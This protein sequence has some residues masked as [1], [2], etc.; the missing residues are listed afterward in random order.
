MWWVSEPYI[1]LR[2]EDEPLGYQPAL[3]PRVAFHLSYRQRG[4]APEDP[5]VFGVGTNWSCSFRSYLTIQYGQIYLQRAGAAFIAYTIGAPQFRDGSVLSTPDGGL[6]YQIEYPDGST[7]SFQQPFTDIQSGSLYFLTAHSDPFGNAIVFNYSTNASVAQLLSVTDPAGQ[8]TSLY[9]DNSTFPNQITRVVDPFNR[10]SYLQYD[11]TSGYLTNITD[12]AG[13]S[14][15]FIYDPSNTGWI[16]NMITPY[17]PT[18]FRYGGTDAQSTYFFDTPN[19]VNRFVEITLPTGGQHLYLYRQDCGDF[20]PVNY[21]SVPTTT[22]LANTLDNV[23][24]CDRN[25][26]HWDPL[27]HVNLSSG[28]VNNLANSDYA[29]GRL[30]HWLLDPAT[31]FTSD[32]LSLEGAPSPDGITPGQITWYDYDG[33]AAGNNYLGTNGL[34]SLV[35]L[36]LPDGTTR[37]N[38]FIRSLPHSQI[39]QTISTYTPN[40]SSTVLLRTNTYVYSTNGVDLLQAIGADGVTTAAYAYDNFHQVLFATN[41]LEEV[42]SYTYNANEQITSVTQ[43]DGLVTTDIYG[44]NGFLAQTDCRRLFHQ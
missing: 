33:K 12:V 24:Q 34:P 43:P 40:Q 11:A 16:T 4:P 8:T 35:A 42:T 18:A 22:P 14:T 23:D 20:M 19:Q 44:A 1:N 36:V 13:L 3:G 32:G 2:L 37:F 5:A 39:I 31:G 17:G 29:I 28:D 15:S 30:R 21:A 10:T 25:S 41:A 27:Q 9:Y 38:H 26:F 6:T 7:D